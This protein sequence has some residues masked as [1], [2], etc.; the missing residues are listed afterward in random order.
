MLEQAH[1]PFRFELPF[2]VFHKA[3]SEKGKER[4]IGGIITTDKTDRQ[5]E[6][7]L[8]GG[9]DFSEF[10]SNGWF[11]DNHSR[12]TTGI[13]GYP[14][15]VKKITHRGRPAHY[16]EGY[17]I[18]GHEPADKIWQL[19]NALQK[20]GRRLGFSI[21]GAVSRREGQSGSV[22]AEAKVRNVAI[23]NCPVN[24]DT[25]LEVLAKSLM[26]AEQE[27][28]WLQRAMMAGQAINDPGTAPGEGF[29]LRAESME[30]KPKRRKKRL[31]KSEALAM[32]MTRYRGMT[33]EKAERILSYHAARQAAQGG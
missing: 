21:E 18:E 13:V 19:A 22:I 2:E 25:G 12:E 5:A 14:Q 3:G 8:Q 26:A 1:I 28:T 11:N 33:V 32:L 23:T 4:R 24:T 31:T 7:V 17:L 6:R 10:L 20:T 29:P 30:R 16:V 27:G 9:L 15:L